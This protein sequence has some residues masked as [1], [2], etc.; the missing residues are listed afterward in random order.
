M[1]LKLRR[2]FHKFFKILIIFLIGMLVINLVLFACLYVNHRS[3]LKQ[4][5]A[6]LTPPGHMVEVNGHDIHV[7]TAGQESSDMTL[8]FLH[9]GKIVDDAVA[10]QP[11]FAE[12]Q[13]DYGLVY[14]DRSGFGYS[15]N[16]GAARD[17]DTIL[18]ETRLALQQSG[19]EAPYVLVA[20]GTS[21]VEAVHWANKYPDEVQAIIGISMNYPE[22]FSV[23]TTEEYCGFFDYL[24]AGFCKI[25]GMRLIQGI[26]PSN[27]FGVYTDTQMR[28]RNALIARG[29]YT[30]DMYNED[31]ATV[32][33]AAKVAQEGWPEELDMYLLYANPLMEPYIS[34]DTAIQ[35]QYQ[36][37]LQDNPDVDY[38]SVYNEAFREYFKSYENVTVEEMSGPSRLYTYDP[39][40]LAENIRQYLGNLTK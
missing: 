34:E 36:E 10:L 14:I 35:K 32:D 27:T 17:I 20:M 38:V 31:L 16:S 40:G 4:E 1:D 7:L 15:E 19:R 6:Y 2:F 12:L 9:S 25:G 26:Y 11:L 23:I 33:N 21:G 13:D 24:M 18:E 3:K 22:S 37:T 39:K 30:G 8:V 29:G 5:K 28:T